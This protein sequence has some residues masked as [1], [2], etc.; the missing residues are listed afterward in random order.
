MPVVELN[1]CA[2]DKNLMWRSRQIKKYD[3]TPK[4]ELLRWKRAYL[5]QGGLTSRQRVYLV[6]E[7]TPIFHVKQSKTSRCMVL[8]SVW[9]IAAYLESIKILSL[10]KSNEK[11]IIFAIK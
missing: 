5:A 7:V 2:D 8:Y 10:R 3:V 6:E 11:M 9:R 4:A 1:F